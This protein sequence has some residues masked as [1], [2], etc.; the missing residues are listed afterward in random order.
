M[1]EPGFKRLWTMPRRAM[2]GGTIAEFSPRG[3]YLVE[4]SRARYHRRPDAYAPGTEPHFTGELGHVDSFRFIT[5]PPIE[6]TAAELALK[7]KAGAEQLGRVLILGGAGYSD[8]FTRGYL[9]AMRSGGAAILMGMDLASGPDWTASYSWPDLVPE[10]PR[11]ALTLQDLQRITRAEL[12]RGRR[13]DKL[14][15]LSA[16]GAIARG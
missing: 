4:Q 7:M 8:T 10:P 15:Q 2:R 5:S 3:R 12:K 14:R 1:N 13:A 11:P 6:S 9:A 16:K